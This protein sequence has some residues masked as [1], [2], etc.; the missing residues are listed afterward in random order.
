MKDIIEMNELEHEKAF[1]DYVIQNFSEITTKKCMNAVKELRKSGKSWEWLHY[2]LLKKSAAKYEEFGFGLWFNTNFYGS[3]N[4]SIKRDRK[5]AAISD[6]EI[7]EWLYSVSGNLDN[8][9][10]D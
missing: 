3:V 8:Y 1:K 4:D 10:D 2:A 6:D 5:L 7:E 9:S